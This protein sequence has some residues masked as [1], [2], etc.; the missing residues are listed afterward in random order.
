MLDSM[1]SREV[2]LGNPIRVAEGVYQIRAIG[3]RVT[4]LLAGGEA[5]LVDAGTRGQFGAHRKR[6]V[7]SWLHPGRCALDRAHAPPS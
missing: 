6:P 7:R 5:L 1:E 2:K 3:A 4:V